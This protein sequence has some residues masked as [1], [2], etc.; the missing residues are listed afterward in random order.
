MSDIEIGFG[1]IL[2]ENVEE[3]IP[4]RETVIECTECED[5][6]YYKDFTPSN[7]AFCCQCQNVRV[8]SYPTTQPASFLT[9]MTL[10]YKSAPKI[11]DISY[12]EYCKIKGIEF[13]KKRE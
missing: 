10:T 4:N 5:K 9:Y 3:W 6:L 2:S 12:E 1:A 11:Y 13:E 7:S 8:G